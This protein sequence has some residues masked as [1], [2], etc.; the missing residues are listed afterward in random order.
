MSVIY[1]NPITLGGG[2]GGAGLNIDYGSTAPSDTSK[3]WVPLT[4]KP[5]VV[6]CSPVLNYGTN[7]IELKSAIIPANQVAFPAISRVGRKI[8]ILG[9][10]NSVSAGGMVKTISV[11]NIDSGEM[12]TLSATLSASRMRSYCASVNGKIYLIGGMTNGSTSASNTIE[13]FDPVTNTITACTNLPTAFRAS[14]CNSCVVVGS[15][16]YIMG[17]LYGSGY[18]NLSILYYDTENDT[19][20]DTGKKCITCDAA[21]VYINN[22]IYG[23]GGVNSGGSFFG[24]YWSFDPATLE[25]ATLGTYNYRYMSAASID[26]NRV[27][28]FQGYDSDYNLHNAIQVYDV[29][30]DTFQTL[31]ITTNEKLCNRY[32]V[33]DGLDIF[34]I[35]G[36]KAST[37]TPANRIEKFS[38]NTALQSN[39]LFLQADFGSSNPFP[40]I[41]D[42]KV[43]ITTYLRNAYLG[44]S[45]NIAQPTNAYLYDTATNQW[46]SLNGESYVADMLNALNVMGVN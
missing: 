22:K 41:N 5:D 30:A 11:Y 38:S 8:Y 28:L 33:V 10:S 34:V 32:V 37:A 45:S 26:N 18:F 39:H 2:G 7:T 25:V 23:F 42:A 12:S 15:K 27:F 9:G 36:D 35:G 4:K 3:L 21:C 24:K 44:D 43:K 46:K 19:V 20:V 6:E 29:N 16:I 31:S 1:G 13:A 14:N 17:Y 40:I